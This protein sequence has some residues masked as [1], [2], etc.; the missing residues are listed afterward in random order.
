MRIIHEVPTI[1]KGELSTKSA[2]RGVSEGGVSEGQQFV[3]TPSETSCYVITPRPRKK[4]YQ[5][6]GHFRIQHIEKHRDWWVVPSELKVDF[7][8][9]KANFS[10]K[11]FY[12]KFAKKVEAGSWHTYNVII[13]HYRSSYIIWRHCI[14]HAVCQLPTGFLVWKLVLGVFEL[15]ESDFGIKNARNRDVFV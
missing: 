3:E 11:H 8:S 6:G 13:R 15:A 12:N 2:I 9:K 5:N 14:F 10:Q 4:I 1:H 7:F